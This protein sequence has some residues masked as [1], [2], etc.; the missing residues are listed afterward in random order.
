MG[1]YLSVFL[2]RFS[3]F[4]CNLH[5]S[6]SFILAPAFAVPDSPLLLPSQV[7]SSR[8]QKDL[9]CPRA[10]CCTAWALFQVASFVGSPVFVAPGSFPHE[11]SFLSHSCYIPRPSPATFDQYDTFYE[12]FALPSYLRRASHSRGG[13]CPSHVA[14]R[15]LPWHFFFLPFDTNWCQSR[16]WPHG[17]F[18][19]VVTLETSFW[20]FFFKRLY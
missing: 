11:P 14:P 17:N 13:C 1:R 5:T 12:G 9:L 15:Q 19:V 6:I 8:P 20:K 16:S 18:I 10:F 2:S 3:C 7:R 4:V